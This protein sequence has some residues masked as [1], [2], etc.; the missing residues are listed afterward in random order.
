MNKWYF[1]IYFCLVYG[2]N[3]VGHNKGWMFWAGWPLIVIGTILL[4]KL[5]AQPKSGGDV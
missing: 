4:K 2:G 3:W 5:T 1:S